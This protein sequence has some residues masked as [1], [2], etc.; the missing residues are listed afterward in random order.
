MPQQPV[1]GHEARRLRTREALRAS[2]SALFESIGFEAT[3][4]ADI[5]RGARVSE[6]TFY[7]HFPSKEDVLFAHVDDFA[8]LAIQVAERSESPHAVDRVRAAVGAL[9]DEACSEEAIARQAGIRA[10]LGVRGEI[11]RPLAS[12]LMK[13]ARELSVRIAESTDSRPAQVAPMVGAALGAV[14]GAGLADALVP[15]SPT[16]PREGM[17]QALDA[18][19]LGFRFG[20]LPE[21][22]PIR[23][24]ER[25]DR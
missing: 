15:A 20:R 3:S 17:L 5:A 13:L 2:A 25:L 21:A 4:V 24:P 6:R 12:Q 16:E 7:M 11:P 18:A 22:V 10:A 9:V 14:E 1:N 23:R 19:L 8:A